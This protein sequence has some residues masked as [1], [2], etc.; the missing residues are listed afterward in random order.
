MD[1]SFDLGPHLLRLSQAP[2]VS[3]AGLGSAAG[4]L[5]WT[6]ACAPVLTEGRGVPSC[7]LGPEPTLF[8]SGS[9]LL[10][11][12]RWRLL[13]LLLRNSGGARPHG[14][15]ARLLP[16]WYPT[17][18]PQ[19]RLLAWLPQTPRISPFPPQH[20]RL[21][22][23]PRGPPPGDRP[24]GTAPR[25]QTSPGPPHLLSSSKCP[26]GH[27]RVPALGTSAQIPWAHHGV[28]P[29]SY[30]GHRRGTICP[31]DRRMGG[32]APKGQLLMEGGTPPPRSVAIPRHTAG[33]SQT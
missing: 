12:G 17:V 30:Y 27:E 10:V 29:E 2:A 18:T 20:A 19:Q 25:P 14:Q 6:R 32:E 4:P 5:V 21:V 16:S 23:A 8:P 26:T 24:Q 9:R 13:V 1:V 22:Q 31:R 33:R 3:A 7:R 11:R 15:M 28:V